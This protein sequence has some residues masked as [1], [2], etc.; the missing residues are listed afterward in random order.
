V[1][2]SLL[3]RIRGEFSEMPGLSLTIR[4]ALRLFDLHEDACRLAFAALVRQGFLAQSRS[5]L[6]HRSWQSP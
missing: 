3:N 2:E 4:Q 1:D 6:F 5:G